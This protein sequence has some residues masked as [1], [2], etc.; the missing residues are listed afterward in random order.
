MGFRFPETAGRSEGLR[1]MDP[2]S[3]LLARGLEAGL[4][5]GAVCALVNSDGRVLAEGQVGEAQPGI[6]ADADTVWDLAS[7]T[8]PVATATSLLIL[9]QEG[10]V[11]LDEEVVHFLPG[12]GASL[13]GITL[14][15]C[16]THVSG[17]KPW[18]QLHSHGLT[19]QQAL[20]RVL[21]AERS[22]PPLTGYAYS[23]LG[24][25]L[26]GEVVGAVAGMA[27][28]EFARRY[29]FEPLGM[30]STT[31]RPGPELAPR[32]AATRCADRGRVLVGEVHDGN[33]ATLG[34]V[35]GH[36]GLFGSC[37]DLARY[38]TML[39]RGGSGPDGSILCPLAVREMGRNQNP[40]GLNGHTLGWFA[41]PSGYLPA[42]D[43]LPAD[44]FG[45]TGFTGTS[46]LIAPS[47]GIVVI[48]LTNR[49]YCERDGSEFLRFRRRFH[50][51]VAGCVAG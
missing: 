6:T 29:I 21:H 27:I 50:N 49:V 37:R 18:E 19:P 22:R 5:L 23:D 2:L 47:L 30:E 13:A 44:T 10:Q 36:A 3:A 17:L 39:L 7:L 24:Y 43:F 45:H 48:L 1:T 33:C 51:A 14:R 4:Y 46:L 31:Y 15:H 28:D 26:L 32:M 34:G 9:A 35:A 20:D 8:K 12:A 41:R 40:P 42:G 25:I 11:H 38:A 16:M